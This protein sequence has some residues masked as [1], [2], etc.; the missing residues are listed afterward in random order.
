MTL[1]QLQDLQITAVVFCCQSTVPL[2]RMA[3]DHAGHLG[4]TS[5]CFHYCVTATLSSDECCPVVS[6]YLPDE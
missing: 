6:V 3:P 2:W 4:H 1:R 5:S